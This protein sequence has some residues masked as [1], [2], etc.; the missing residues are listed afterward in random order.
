M[1]QLT[2]EQRAKRNADYLK[3]IFG[4]EDLAAAANGLESAIGS[5]GVGSVRNLQVTKSTKERSP[6]ES[7]QVMIKDPTGLGLKA[8]DHERLEAIIH[9]TKRPAYPIINNSFNASGMWSFLQ[10]DEAVRKRIEHAIRSV[11]RVEL[12]K[13]NFYPYAGTGFVVGKN[14]IITNRHVATM[15]TEGIGT[16]ML[17]YVPGSAGIDFRREIAGEDNT[18]PIMLEIENVLM[19]HPYWDMALLILA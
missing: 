19:I 7:L 2:D 13:S 10:T 15:F 18:A 11:G 16:K 17:R 4:T 12:P 5:G 9:Q 14:T 3:R 6:L 1:S 8:A